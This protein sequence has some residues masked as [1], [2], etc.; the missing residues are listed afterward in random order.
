M[1]LRVKVIVVVMC[2]LQDNT[3]AFLTKAEQKGSEV[4]NDKNL[5]PVAVS[6]N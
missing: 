6:N 2:F 4:M 1:R 5:S 3:D